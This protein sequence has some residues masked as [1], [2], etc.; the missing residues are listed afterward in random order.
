MKNNLTLLAV[1]AAL[2]C[3][4]SGPAA[5]KPPVFPPAPALKFTPPQAERYVLP[6]GLIVYMLEDHTL[7]SV[8]ISALVRTGSQYDTADKAGL[9]SLTASSMRAAGT[10]KYKADDLN[11]RLEFIGADIEAELS[12]EEA[13][14]NAVCLSKNLP[15]VLDM[16]AE[17]LQR[18]AFEEAKVKVE[19]DGMIDG[20]KR[21]NDNPQTM[22]Y[23]EAY[24]RFYG[25]N[26]PYSFRPEKAGVESIT[27]EDMKAF[28]SSF[29]RPNR[30]ILAVAGDFKAA[31]MKDALAKAFGQWEKTDAPLPEIVAPALPSGRQVFYISKQLPQ[32][33]MVLVQPGPKRRHP[34]QEAMYVAN[35]VLGSGGMGSRLFTEVRTNKGLAYSVYSMPIRTN[36]VGSLMAFCGTKNKT[37]GVALDEIIRQIQ[38]MRNA[39]P[40]ADELARAKD[41]IVNSYVFRFSTPMSV[42]DDRMSNEYYGY[43]DD[44]VEKYPSYIAAVTADKVLEVSKRW[45]NPDAALIFV[46]GD[47]AQFDKPLSSY[48]TVATVE[49]D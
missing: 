17:I 41:G 12:L 36:T 21:R 43:P 5:A 46:S 49:A 44:Y 16:T 15:E 1:C 48:G 24:R 23:R 26:H 38:G 13:S 34:D 6:N 11:A 4:A 8:R 18:P 20:I 9:A 35:A 30:T 10:A 19:K 27:V 39:A 33:P 29:Y 37:V 25:L 42:L 40:G 47:A 31:E 2:V 28:H 22:V 32:A 7:P 3:A 45:Y 14:L